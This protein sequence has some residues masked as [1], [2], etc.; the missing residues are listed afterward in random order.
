MNACD[1]ASGSLPFIEA[2]GGLQVGDRAFGHEGC[3]RATLGEE[4]QPELSAGV[5]LRQAQP[6][7]VGD[8]PS[9]LLRHPL[10]AT[11]APVGEARKP[12]AMR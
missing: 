8:A 6:L 5:L 12:P 10:R 7:G 4:T 2:E 9:Q 11:E 3:T 1:H